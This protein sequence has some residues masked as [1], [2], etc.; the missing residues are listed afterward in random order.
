M[1]KIPVAEAYFHS[2]GEID[3][4][5]LPNKI[6]IISVGNKKQLATIVM[7]IKAI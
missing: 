6:L 3:K 1:A 7:A 2:N 5:S 4:Y